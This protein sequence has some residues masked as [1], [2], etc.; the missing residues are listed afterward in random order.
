MLL[1][2]LVDFDKTD[3]IVT[4]PAKKETEVY[5]TGRFG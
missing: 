2:E 3:K 4:N 5:L 1:G